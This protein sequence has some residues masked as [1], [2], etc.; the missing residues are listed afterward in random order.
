MSILFRLRQCSTSSCTTRGV[1]RRML[2][3]SGGWL[4]TTGLEEI[5]A[6]IGYQPQPGFYGMVATH[7]FGEV[8]SILSQSWV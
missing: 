2:L 5:A 4:L 7:S 6:I 1:G 8:Q 3:V